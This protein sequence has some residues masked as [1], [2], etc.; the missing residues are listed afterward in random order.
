MSKNKKMKRKIYLLFSIS[1][2][3][4]G[5]CTKDFE[6]INTNPN[7]PIEVQPSLLLRQVIYDY[8]EEMSYE[9][10]VAG[11]LLGQ[12]FTA[13]D[14]NLFDRHSLTEPQFGGNPWFPI[15]TNLRDNEIIIDF[16]RSNPSAAV[17]EGPALILKSY[18]SAA[19]TDIFGDVPYSEALN[20][21]EGNVTPAYDSQELIYT[22][23]DGILSN[24]D[25]GIALLQAYNGAQSLEGD[26]LFNGNLEAWIKF[27]YSLK[28]KYLMRL[29]NKMDVST[30]VQSVF[31]SN[32]LMASNVDNATFD[33]TD[34]PPNNFRMATLRAGDFNLFIMSETMEEIL[35]NWND[36]RMNTFFR[37][38]G[39]DPTGTEFK[40]FLNGPDASSTSISVA[41]FSLS[42]IIFRENTSA[43]DASFITAAEVQ[44][45]LA[46]A[47]ERGFISENAEDYYNAGVMLSFEYWNTPLPVDY[48][49]SG[50][51]AYNQNGNDPIEQII[52]Q[53][54]LHNIINGYEGWIEYRR[55]G[56][57]QLKTISASL[58]NDLI[59]VR[60]PYPADEEA[61]NRENYNNATATNQNSINSPVWWDE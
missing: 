40:G 22:G 27:G 29:S 20:G 50:N 33:F 37:P 21:K 48:L 18:M 32:N 51:T 26:I 24:L 34:G 35:K 7:A 52:S 46:E 9:G 39:N 14:F 28:L 5:S 10:F 36:P 41:D 57:P 49:T 60:L 16:A 38:I 30:L 6:E 42:G 25:K 4:L 43:L 54:W 47:A 55:T 31:N 2:I 3:F 45:L 12:Y 58:N 23:E 1:L 17:Y 11:N 56:F 8:G 15:Y 19:L 59:P 44:F 61:L 53:K 13:I